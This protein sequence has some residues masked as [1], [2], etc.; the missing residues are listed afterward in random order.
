ML[1][2]FDLG[3]GG[4]GIKRIIFTTEPGFIRVI[5]AVILPITHGAVVIQTLPIVTKEFT[6]CS[7]DYTYT[8]LWP[9]GIFPE[10]TTTIS[11]KLMF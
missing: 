7:K 1:P 11:I 8:I 6:F 5:P 4:G 3:G 10:I 9:L 2:I